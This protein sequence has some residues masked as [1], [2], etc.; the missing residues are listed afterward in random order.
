MYAT[1]IKNVNMREISNLITSFKAKKEENND[2]EKHYR[3]KAYT[4]NISE[5][6]KL[7]SFIGS[8]VGTIIPVAMMLKKQKI[9]NPLKLKYELG[10]MVKVSAGSIIGG[11]G[12]GLIG[13]EKN[14][15]INRLNEGFFQFMNAIV[16][17]CIVGYLINLC[18]SSTKYN[19]KA[20]KILSILGGLIFGM[21]GAATLTNLIID[22][23]D[24]YPDR[25]LSAKDTLANIDD[26]LG[27]LALAKIPIVDKLNLAGFLP[28][29]YAS[30]GYRAGESN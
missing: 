29:I 6:D 7:K 18:E 12:L 3:T 10:D 23:K 24:K 16:P 2:G 26:G 25:K 30:C 4:R 19:T 9:K 27:A 1:P 28:L 21:F 8:S 17:T 15:K 5:Y 20:Y 22:P 14:V 11:V 13:E